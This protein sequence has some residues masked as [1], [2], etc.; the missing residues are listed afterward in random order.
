M[1]I[2]SRE[3]PYTG[4]NDPA[5]MM[6]VLSRRH[7]KRPEDTIPKDSKQGD[8]LWSLLKTCWSWDPKE[9]P[10]APYVVSAI[11]T[12]RSED[13][14]VEPP[15]T[16]AMSPSPRSPPGSNTS[17]TKK[18]PETPEGVLAIQRKRPRLERDQPA[19][20]PIAHQ[21]LISKA[22]E[23]LNYVSSQKDALTEH[24]PELKYSID[25]LTDLLYEAHKLGVD[26]PE[27][28]QLELLSSRVC[29][30]QQKTRPLLLELDSY[31]G[32]DDAAS[33]VKL[34]ELVAV[35][36]GLRLPLDDEFAKLE[37]LVTRL[38][39]LRDLQTTNVNRLT[40]DQAEAFFLRGQ[41]A[42]V[43]PTHQAMIELTR[44]ATSG[45]Q[46]MNSA[47]SI[48][49]QPQPDMRDLDR[50]LPVAANSIPTLPYMLGKLTQVRSRG[51]E[52][53][54]KVEA[55]LRPPKGT[56]V[57]IDD[58]IKVAT[59]ALDEVFFPAAKELLALLDEA[60]TWEKTCEDIMSGGFN[61]RGNTKVLDEVRAM[62]DQGK[63][64][65]GAFQMPWFEEVMRQLA[66]HDD[67]VSQL[68]WTRSGLSASDLDSI[69]RDM[70]GDRD[71]ECVPP[72]N[73]E[74]TC[75]CLEPVVVDE[76]AQVV[77][78]DHCLVRFHIKCVEGSC[79]F[80]DDRTWDKL[81]GEPRTF[82]LWYE[83]AGALSRYYSPDYRAL[84]AIVLF[85]GGG[86]ALTEPIIN[87]I[88]QLGKQESPDPATVPQIR[89]FMRKLYRIRL[90]I[91]ARPEVFAYG[92]SLA[93]L[94]RQM[95]L[96]PRTKHMARQKPKFV[97][98][99]EMD[100]LPEFPCPLCDD[101]GCDSDSDSDFNS[102][103]QDGWYH[104]S[105]RCSKC[106]SRYHKRCIALSN[107]DRVPEPFV[108]PLCLLKSGES[109]GPAE[110]RVMYHGTDRGVDDDPEENAKYVDVKACLD[111][112][113]W[114]VIRRAL[115][116]PVRPT[117]TVK[118]FL[119]IPG[120]NSTVEEPE[121]HPQPHSEA[122]AESTL[123]QHTDERLPSGEWFGSA[124][125]FN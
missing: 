11:E 89:H 54:K 30:F 68:P 111:N 102:D 15:E 122:S 46:W 55:C 95:T 19:Q 45:L 63:S 120:T 39:F 113:S 75:V 33:L 3:L 115:P 71:A 87:L 17:E 14:L 13:L 79:P 43:P 78:C 106:Q 42:G 28:A 10:E 67:W 59:A 92:L 94:H 50:L 81:M 105:T 101:Y 7:P 107:T 21:H 74:C 85:N 4:R 24:A 47:A 35:G 70:T 83:T 93:H 57:R 25:D 123:S 69:V 80:C 73:E 8:T 16:S 125:E 40:L 6:A 23:T 52:Y 1:E 99:F 60:R 58:A 116:P 38:Q 29:G 31:R 26:A 2:I 118:L 112:Y 114:R 18:R 27:T 100:L 90:E 84:R 66:V 103:L 41:H 88:K 86:S 44:V 5:V 51:R 117:I 108:C 56:L 20:I 110:V 53:E 9:R 104:L 77:Q 62:R 109:Y 96:Q 64:K 72:N 98:D 37:P 36:K 91:S 65:F 119:F 49:T 82:K 12:I 121:S 22:T 76:S 32:L 34:E 61:A 97:F 124:C 48:L